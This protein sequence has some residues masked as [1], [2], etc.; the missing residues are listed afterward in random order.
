MV[1]RRSRKSVLEYDPLAWLAEDDDSED[2]EVLQESTA[3]EE[4]DSKK[5]SNNNASGTDEAKAETTVI[6]NVDFGFFESDGDETENRPIS[7]ESVVSLGN[8][9]TLKTVSEFKQCIEKK[10]ANSGSVTLDPTDLQK[11]D[12]AGLQLLYSL[13][14]SLEKTGQSLSWTSKNFTIE[15]AAGLIGLPDLCD[16]TMTAGFG[17]FEDEDVDKDLSQ[18]FGFF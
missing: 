13:Q 16:N 5:A 3:N 1:A 9:L 8:S 14:Q 12:T 18:G 2:D 10:L 7:G 15:S 17:F 11:I 4:A 6:E